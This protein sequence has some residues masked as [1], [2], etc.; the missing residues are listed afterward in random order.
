MKQ[1][2][3]IVF[4]E[5]DKQNKTG[6]NGFPNLQRYKVMCTKINKGWTISELS[7]DRWKYDTLLYVVKTWST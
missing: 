7:Y 6:R 5:C 1:N 3:L 4:E 2:F